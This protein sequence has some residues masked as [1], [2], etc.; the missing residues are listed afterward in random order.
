VVTSLEAFAVLMGFANIVL[1]VRR[2][3]WNYPFGL[4]TVAVYA[5]IF[6][7]QKLYSDAILQL[8]FFA[9]Q[10]YGWYAW[11]RAGGVEE[12]VAVRRMSRSVRI[13]WIGGIA[14]ITLLWGL[15]MRINTDASYPWWDGAIAVTSIAAQILLS[16]RLIENW[17]L[18]IAIDV[19]AVPL[20]ALKSLYL[21]AS[22]Y[23]VYLI[24]SVLGWRAWDQS[25]RGRTA[26]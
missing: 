4:A 23:L 11:W 16:R 18:W 22:L 6:F 15:G 20:Y 26:G 9:I 7:E 8:F 13:A 24:L 21:T 2:S 3:I 1:L 17:L 19:A 12:R 10:I 5:H 25:S 14:T